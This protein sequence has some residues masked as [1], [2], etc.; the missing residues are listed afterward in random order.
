M[1]HSSVNIVSRTIPVGKESEMSNLLKSF[2]EEAKQAQ[3]PLYVLITGEKGSDGK[4]WCPDCVKADALMEKLVYNNQQ[5]KG[6]FVTCPVDRST[7]KNGIPVPCEDGMACP[8]PTKHQ[9]RTNQF[10]VTAIPTL[11]KMDG[12][13]P[14]ER[15]VEADV[16]DSEKLKKFIGIDQ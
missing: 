5:A 2:A 7:Y 14:V 13:D 8:M 3:L 1:S 4:S 10:K 15:L 9:Y 11:Y 16:Y 12:I 6:L